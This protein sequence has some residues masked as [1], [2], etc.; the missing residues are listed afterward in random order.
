MD[1]S[2]AKHLLIDADGLLYSALLACE[3][4]TD[5]GNDVWSLTVNL[6]EARDILRARLKEL[7]GG[8]PYTLILTG[9]KLFRKAVYPEYKA[10][11]KDKRKPVGFKAL[12]EEMLAGEYGTCLVEECLEADDLCGILAT[13]PTNKGKVIVVSDDKDLKTVPCLLLRNN[14]LELVTEEAADFNMYLQ[15]LAG[16]TSD[17]YPGCKGYGSVKATKLLNGKGASWATVR[18][19][20]TQSGA[21]EQ[22]AVSM[23]RMARILRWTDW[24]TEK[25]EPILWAP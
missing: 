11:R 12:R 14:E 4:E 13:K 19:A 23:I 8:S 6:Q 15:A 1:G 20:F 3:Q 10:N 2:S 25:K 21:T 18:D 16:D 9:S 22:D 24:D 7:V 17:G 5:W